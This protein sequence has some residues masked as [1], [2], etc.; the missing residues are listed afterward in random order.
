MRRI[1]LAL[2]VFLSPLILLEYLNFT[3]FCYSQGRYYSDE[4]LIDIA[5][6]DITRTHSPSNPEKNKRYESVG[7]FR[8]QN[9]ECCIVYNY[10]HPF[11]DPI[12]V[13]IFGFYRVLVE[14][15][16]RA[17]ESSGIDNFY[18]SLTSFDACGQI[19]RRQGIPESRSRIIPTGAG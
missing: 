16:Y 18:D 10:G 7:E 4:Q 9:P 11:L 8:Q 1:F 14:V 13:R 12:W 6:S 5:I 17:N 2:L 19:I 3:G 15:W